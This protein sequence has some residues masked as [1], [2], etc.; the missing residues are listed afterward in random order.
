MAMTTTTTTTTTICSTISPLKSPCTSLQPPSVS[1]SSSSWKFGTNL[2]SKEAVTIAAANEAVVLARAAVKVARDAVALASLT[3]EVWFD[4]EGGRGVER[5]GRSDL[6]F[7]RK[8]RR[9]RRKGFGRLEVDDRKDGQCQRLVMYEPVQSEYFGW[10]EEAELCLRLQD[11]A[12]LDAV[13]RRI[14]ET[15]EYEPTLEQL[16]KALEMKKRSVNRILC[17]GRESLKSI[18]C[19]HRKLVISIAIDYQGK[20]LGLQDLIQEG[21]IGLLRGAQRF[22]PKRG[23]KLST[24][25]YWWIKEAIISAISKNGRLIRLPEL[26]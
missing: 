22:D 11:Q 3:E 21:S 2:L 14:A 23:Y 16:A 7:R 12:R 9:K 18:T 19:S 1:S 5:D 10:P 8:K 15:Q 20:G 25:A 6:M 24:Y 17:N 13:R 26:S 4:G